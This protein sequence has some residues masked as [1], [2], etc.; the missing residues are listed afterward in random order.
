MSKKQ[1]S[2][3]EFNRQG[4]IRQVENVLDGVTEQERQDRE[5]QELIKERMKT[6]EVHK[7]PRQHSDRELRELIEKRKKMVKVIKLV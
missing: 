5:L 3:E 7:L 4:R 1:I 2:N 6:A